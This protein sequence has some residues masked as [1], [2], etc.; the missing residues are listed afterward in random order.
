MAGRRKIQG[1]LK[2]FQFQ[3]LSFEGMDGQ[4]GG[5]SHTSSKTAQQSSRLL[6]L[7]QMDACLTFLMS[8]GD[9]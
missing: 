4:L 7:G 5:D 6:M 1:L 8:E 3:S 2:R 9:C